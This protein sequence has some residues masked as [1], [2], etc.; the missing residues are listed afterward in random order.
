MPRRPTAKARQRKLSHIFVLDPI[1]SIEIRVGDKQP[2]QTALYGSVRNPT[3]A[4]QRKPQDTAAPL[5]LNAVCWSV[6]N[7]HLTECDT[8]HR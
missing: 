7:K 8:D 3:E 4:G 5:L 6:G 1:I 2:K